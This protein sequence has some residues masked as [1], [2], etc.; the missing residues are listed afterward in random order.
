[1]YYVVK[2]NEYQIFKTDIRLIEVADT[3]EK[4]KALCMAMQAIHPDERYEV[5]TAVHLQ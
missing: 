1:M 4:A 2:V 5:L 3:I